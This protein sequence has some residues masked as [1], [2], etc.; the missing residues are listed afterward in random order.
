MANILEDVEDIRRRGGGILRSMENL[1]EGCRE[2]IRLGE[3][4]ELQHLEG[5]KPRRIII[6]GMG[7]SAIGGLILRDWLLDAST[8][9]YVSAGYHLPGFTDDETLIIAVSYSGNTEETLT[10]L[11]EAMERGCPI[12]TVT[13]NGRM[14]KISEERGIPLIPLPRGLQPRASLPQQLFSIAVALR[15]IGVEAPWDEVGEAIEVLEQ[16]RP[17]L[18]PEKSPEANEAKSLALGLWGYIP[19][20]YAPRRM[21]A[22]AYR[23]R[24]QL[25]ENAKLPACSASLPEGFHNAV[26]GREGPKELLERLAALIIREPD[27]GEKLKRRINAFRELLEESFGRVLE[28]WARGRGLLPKILSALYIG[29]YTS[30]YLALLYGYDPSKIKS[31]ELLKRVG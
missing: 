4:V 30:L 12:L 31:I 29:D 14:R 3:E 19:H 18:A 25:N 28:L 27:E 11:M 1:P 5:L 15:R 8:P 9:I 17:Q 6:A 22:V 20:I 13:S 10:A 21:E 16:L 26:M 2:G 7:G 24:T 23:L